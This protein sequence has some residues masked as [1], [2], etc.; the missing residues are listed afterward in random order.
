MRN[1][2]SQN[3]RDPV[4]PHVTVVW[5]SSWLPQLPGQKQQLARDIRR[6]RAPARFCDGRDDDGQNE[7]SASV[8]RALRPI[9]GDLSAPLCHSS[10]PSRT[11]YHCLVPTPS[12]ALRRHCR[13]LVQIRAFKVQTV[14]K[15]YFPAPINSDMSSIHTQRAKRWEMTFCAEWI[16]NSVQCCHK[17]TAGKQ[18]F[19]KWLVTMVPVE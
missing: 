1:G 3:R 13:L 17:T 10:V 9:G 6:T 18:Q 16:N 8:T 2:P 14:D 7:G 12:N 15:T 5:V 4:C 19:E 11:K